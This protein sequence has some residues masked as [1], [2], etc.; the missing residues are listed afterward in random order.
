MLSYGFIV[1]AFI[2]LCSSLGELRLLEIGAMA[3]PC[4]KETPPFGGATLD[5][6]DDEYETYWA[7]TDDNLTRITGF[8]ACTCCLDDNGD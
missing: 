3:Q 8:R 4:P 5:G 7:V 2:L 1:F 6:S